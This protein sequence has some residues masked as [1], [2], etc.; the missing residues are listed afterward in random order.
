MNEANLTPQGIRALRTIN[1]V[2]RDLGDCPLGDQLTAGLLAVEALLEVWG[3]ERAQGL[4]RYSYRELMAE[5]NARNLAGDRDPHTEQPLSPSPAMAALVKT[6][7]YEGKSFTLKIHPG[8]YMMVNYDDHPGY[9]SLVSL[10]PGT[11]P[12]SPDPADYELSTLGIPVRRGSEVDVD[13]QVA[14]ACRKLIALERESEHR[15]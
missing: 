8:N 10:H 11:G 12:P 2:A 5:L 3:E 9:W 15:A 6:H 4:A 7:L 1:D 13:Q 14:D